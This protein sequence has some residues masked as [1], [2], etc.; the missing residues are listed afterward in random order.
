MRTPL[1]PYLAAEVPDAATAGSGL[2]FVYAALFLAQVA[3]A[4]VVGGALVALAPSAARPHDLTSS[5]LLTMAALHLPLGLLLAWAVSRRPGKGSALVGALTAAVVLSVPAWFAVLL[6]ITG[7][8]GGF[9]AAGWSLVA[10]GY[11]GGLALTPGWVRGAMRPAEPEPT[12]RAAAA[13]AEGDP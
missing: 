5:V 3:L 1:A 11:A 9:V 10:L 7:Q 13:A 6:A 2:R 4:V 12:P 8:R